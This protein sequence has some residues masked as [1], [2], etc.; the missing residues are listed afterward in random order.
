MKFNVE[1]LLVASFAVVAL[2]FAASPA[3][4]VDADANSLEQPT[5]EVS[6]QGCPL[7]PQAVAPITADE[8]ITA[9]GPITADAPIT[10]ASPITVTDVGTDC[11]IGEN[12]FSCT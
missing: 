1:L 10:A 3:A 11:V 6:T 12:E 2:S 9:D 5:L 7:C 8:P 4:A